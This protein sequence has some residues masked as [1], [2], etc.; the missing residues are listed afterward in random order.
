MKKRESMD[1]K[2]KKEEYS[3]ED[4]SRRNQESRER[5][6][7]S[8]GQPLTRTNTHRVSKSGLRGDRN[9]YEAATYDGKRG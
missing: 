2:T 7:Q 8:L 3:E 9:L 4:S 1:G 5:N 6:P